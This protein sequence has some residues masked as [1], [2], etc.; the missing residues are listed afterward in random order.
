MAEAIGRAR[1]DAKALAGG[2]VDA[3]LVEN[4]G[5]VPFFK[6]QVPPITV[7]AM[8]RLALEV[9]QEVGEKMVLGINVLRND[10]QAAAAVAGVCEAD[11]I[12][13]NIH[14]G[15]RLTDQGIIEG[16][17]FETIRSIKE[18]DVDLSK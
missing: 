1:S 17:C 5:D 11:F 14:M 12:R 13:V 9:R 7:A 4:Y 2:G 18:W 6:D 16:R 8:T 3:I 15:A 10:A